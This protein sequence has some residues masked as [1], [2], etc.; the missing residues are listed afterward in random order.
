M[1]T[2]PSGTSI[3]YS[4]RDIYWSVDSPVKFILRIGLILEWDM[5][6]FLLV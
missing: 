2:D 3:L 6:T 1:E 5:L 4:I